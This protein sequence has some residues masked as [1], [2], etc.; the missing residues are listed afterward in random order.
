MTG[1]AVTGSVV[2]D[3]LAVGDPTPVDDAG[4]VQAPEAVA[5]G[6]QATDATTEVAPEPGPRELAVLDTTATVPG[7]IVTPTEAQSPQASVAATGTISGTVVVGNTPKGNVPVKD[8]TV[9]VGSQT[10]TTAADGTFTLTGLSAGPHTVTVTPPSSIDAKDLATSS[11]TVADV[12]DGRTG[13]T[14][15]VRFLDRNCDADFAAGS[16]A[17]QDYYTKYKDLFGDVSGLD[18]DKDG[19]ACDWGASGTSN[20][21]YTSAASARPAVTGGALAHT[22]SQVAA[23]VLAASSMILAGIALLRRGAAA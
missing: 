18:A 11:L 17:A 15:D 1:S 9:A 23:P 5:P 13:L 19:N 3:P 12:V 7:G 14:V 20:T 16:R 2:T 4:A 21:A 6:P 22:G 8:A 10:V